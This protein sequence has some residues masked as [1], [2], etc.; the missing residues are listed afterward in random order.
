MKK[1]G[2]ETK[3]SGPLTLPPLTGV[4]NLMAAVPRSSALRVDG[5]NL[6]S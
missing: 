5:V 6:L 3:E 4:F 2:G 1:E